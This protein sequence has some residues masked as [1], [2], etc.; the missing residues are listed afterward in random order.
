MT[1]MDKWHMR[2]GGMNQ[3]MLVGTDELYSR[4]EKYYA[5]ESRENEEPFPSK[6]SGL[7]LND[8]KY[9]GFRSWYNQIP[10]RIDNR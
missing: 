9:E 1:W 4:R 10:G 2:K 3:D 5:E 8:I 7:I 6:D